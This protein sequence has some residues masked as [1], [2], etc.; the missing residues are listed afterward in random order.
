MQELGRIGENSQEIV[1]PIERSGISQGN[2]VHFSVTNLDVSKHNR[3]MNK[4]SQTLYDQGTPNRQHWNKIKTIKIQYQ[5]QQ[6]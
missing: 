3:K 1:D 2:Q 5:S 4:N 6:N